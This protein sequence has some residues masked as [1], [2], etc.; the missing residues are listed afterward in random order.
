VILKD[1]TSMRG[2]DD[3]RLDA[4]FGAYRAACAGPEPSANFMPNLW[5]RIEARQSFSFSLRR[6][7]NAFA[8]AAMALSLALGIYMAIP[9][10]NSPLS[11]QSYLE[12]LTEATTPDAQEFVNPVTVDLADR[13][14]R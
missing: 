6:M 11:A 9:R 7:A 8:T 13:P 12:A 14:I 4:L 1:M 10:S 3:Q 5:A 2:N